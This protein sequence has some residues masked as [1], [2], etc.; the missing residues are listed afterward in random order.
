LF[1]CITGWQRNISEAICQ[2]YGAHAYGTKAARIGCSKSCNTLQELYR[3]HAKSLY[4]QCSREQGH[5]SHG[6][7]EAKARNLHHSQFRGENNL[8]TFQGEENFLG[9]LGGKEILAH[10]RL[11]DFLRGNVY[12][13]D[14]VFRGKCV[15]I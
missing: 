7:N 12:I 9:I 5:P 1:I 2:K 10:E 13:L 4:V 11:S 6:G 8:F 15:Y 3:M 14:D